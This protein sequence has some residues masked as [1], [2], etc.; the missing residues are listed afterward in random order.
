MRSFCEAFD[1]N[2]YVDDDSASDALGFCHG[3]AGML[4]IAD[5]FGLYA[6]LEKALHL[7]DYLEAYLL[8]R[9]DE[10]LKLA[11][12]NATFLTGANGILAAL[13]CKQGGQRAWLSHL[14]LR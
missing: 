14:A 8:D 13:L 2:F 3:V 1:E 5:T 4:A 6:G 9:I 10:V 12:E 7:R 11:S